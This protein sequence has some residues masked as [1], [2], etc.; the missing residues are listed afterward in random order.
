[1]NFKNCNYEATDKQEKD[2]DKEYSEF[3]SDEREEFGKI[4]QPLLSWYAKQ[5]RQLPWRESKEP[6][7]IW[8]SE[9]MLQQTRVEAVIPYFKKF[10]QKFPNIEMLAQAEE[11]TVLKMW[12]GLGYYSRARNLR[13]AAIKICEE[14]E[15]VFPVH[16]KDILALPG[17]GK[18]TAGAISS[19]A[20]GMPYA[21]VDGN[22]LRV[23]TRLKESNENIHDE[24]F[25]KSVGKKLEAVYPEKH[26]S[27]FTQALMELGAI[28]CVPNGVPKCQ[29]CP[30]KKECAAYKNG[31]QLEYPKK[32]VKAQRK[33]IDK[34]V[35]LLSCGEYIAVHKRAKEGLLGGMWQFPNIDEKMNIAQIKEWLEERKISAISIEKH[36]T[37]KHIFTHLEWNMSCYSVQCDSKNQD[38]EWVSKEELNQKIPLP[39]AFRKC[40]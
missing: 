2:I 39:T 28:I 32:N 17:I 36:K 7:S 16:Y 29:E 6:Y 20:F 10:M 24:I 21:A 31:T 13:K 1:M 11:E 30:L 14:F 19:I 15:G 37:V 27:E 33:K 25:R 34:T 8:V 18:Y 40:I 35:F 22:V 5:A 12:E 23:V 38:Y 26:C 4:V 3:S 9:I